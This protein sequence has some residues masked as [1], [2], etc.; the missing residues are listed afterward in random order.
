MISFSAVSVSPSFLTRGGLGF[1]SFFS[2]LD[3][4]VSLTSASA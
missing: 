4:V 2:G 1:V 3:G